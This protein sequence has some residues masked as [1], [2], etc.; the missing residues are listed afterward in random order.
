MEDEARKCL[1]HETFLGD[2]F[3]REARQDHKIW[4][5]MELSVPLKIIYSQTHHE[6]FAPHSR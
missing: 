1:F 6:L 4:I 3:W 5:F 2:K